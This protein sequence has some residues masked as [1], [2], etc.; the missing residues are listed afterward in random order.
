MYIKS[1]TKLF[2]L[3]IAMP[4]ILAACSGSGSNMLYSKTEVIGASIGIDVATRTPSI[5]LGSAGQD[6]A[7]V[8][9]VRDNADGEPTV[10]TG[11]RKQW[12]PETGNIILEIEDSLSVCGAFGGMVSSGSGNNQLVV[13]KVF[14]TGGAAQAVCDGIAEM[15]ANTNLDEESE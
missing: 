4:L 12:D 3:A 14:A 15:Y 13:D 9:A 5:K 10:V 1:W 2:L 7:K 8:P 6:V 11:I